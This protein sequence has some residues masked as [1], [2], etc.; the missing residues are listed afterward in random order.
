MT[1]QFEEIKRTFIKNSINELLKVKNKLI[2]ENKSDSNS[3]LRE[4]AN[5]VFMVMHDISGTA[6]MV[7]LEPLALVSRKLELIF[8]K[9]RQDEKVFSEQIRVQ[10]IRGVDTIIDELRCYSKKIAL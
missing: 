3:K 8:N 2:D 10:A 4:I 5:E 9:I 6:P 7:G 1:D